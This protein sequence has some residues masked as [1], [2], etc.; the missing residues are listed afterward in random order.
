MYL[1]RPIF[2][3]VIVPEQLLHYLHELNIEVLDFLK[4]QLNDFWLDI[5]HCVTPLHQWCY[6][7]AVLLSL[8]PSM[9]LLCC[10]ATPDLF[11][12]GELTALVGTDLF[13]FLQMT[14]RMEIRD[15]GLQ[16]DL[17]LL[18]L[19]QVSQEPDILQS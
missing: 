5:L 3:N 15:R 8:A 19:L 12:S 16:P 11:P 2:F 17:D 13:N 4:Q 14:L 7:G 18:N 6:S 9:Q 1:S 10:V